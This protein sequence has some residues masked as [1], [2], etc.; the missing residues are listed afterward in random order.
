MLSVFFSN[1]TSTSLLL[2]AHL[3]VSFL[4]AARNAVIGYPLANKRMF[5][6]DC[7]QQSCGIHRIPDKGCQ[8]VWAHNVVDGEYRFVAIL[9]YTKQPQSLICNC[10]PLK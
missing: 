1:P 4:L 10:A 9:V 7:V 5:P 6:Y 8:S 3:W 2:A